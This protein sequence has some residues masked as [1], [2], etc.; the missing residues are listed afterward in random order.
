MG[1]LGPCKSLKMKFLF[2]LPAQNVKF[3]RYNL[4]FLHFYEKKME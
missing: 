1:N 4:H 3:M 2:F